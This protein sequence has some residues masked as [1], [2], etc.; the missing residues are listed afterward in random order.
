[1]LAAME[2]GVTPGMFW[3]KLFA[4]GEWL[5]PTCTMGSRAKVVRGTLSVPPPV[6]GLGVVGVFWLVSAS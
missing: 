5:L 1:M 6:T 3:K 2:T 4:S